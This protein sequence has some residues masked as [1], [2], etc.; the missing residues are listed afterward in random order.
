MEKQRYQGPLFSQI[1][2]KTGKTTTG[3][4]VWTPFDHGID[5]RSI[6]TPDAT[7]FIEP[8]DDVVS[9]RAKQ[10]CLSSDIESIAEELRAPASLRDVC[11]YYRHVC[12][13]G[14]SY[15]NECAHLLS[16]AF[17]RAGYSEL[18][19]ASQITARCKSGAGRAIRAFDMLRWFQSKQREF[20]SGVIPEGNGV[21]ATYQEKPGWKHVLI[22][23]T[24]AWKYCG[25]NDYPDWPVQY[26]YR[27]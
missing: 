2:P 14:D 7:E 9:T 21:W 26:N 27:W 3:V 25:T 24:D 17:I 13:G 4:F 23:D 5:V 1:D 22:S 10:P 18:L 16:N 11:K 6:Y 12:D 19:T 20:R 8:A 15:R